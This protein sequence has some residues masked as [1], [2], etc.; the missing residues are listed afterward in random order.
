LAVIAGRP[1]R[2]ALLPSRLSAL[3][4]SRTGSLL[5]FVA[6]RILWMVPIVFFVILITFLLMHLAPGSPW[7]KAGGRQLSAVV[8]HNLDAKYGLNQ[9]EYKQ[10][11]LYVWNVLHFDFGLSYQYEGKTVTSLILEGLPYTATIGTL[12]FLL[13]VPVGVGLGILAALR[14]NTRVDYA[15]MGFPR[16]PRRSQA[17]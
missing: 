6:K 14:Q 16:S 1:T 3:T 15:T 2:G 8:V 10:F 5:I 17:S 12:A 9:P 4:D 7:D 13:I 11:E